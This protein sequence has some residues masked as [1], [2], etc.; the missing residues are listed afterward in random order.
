M[1]HVDLLNTEG[2]AT[3]HNI[4]LFNRLP[5]L[6]YV[7]DGFDRLVL[8]DD[9]TSHDDCA[10]FQT[11][12][13]ALYETFNCGPHST[14]EDL[15]RDPI[16][17]LPASWSISRHVTYIAVHGNQAKNLKKAI[18]AFFENRICG[19]GLFALSCG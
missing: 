1:G 19:R 5:R 11:T 7:C 4:R 18:E 17:Y 3:G 14:G 6:R 15:L 9:T 12:K 16:E 13:A 10:G 8:H 2:G